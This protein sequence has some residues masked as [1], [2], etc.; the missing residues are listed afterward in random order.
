MVQGDAFD[1]L[2]L[3]DELKTAVNQDLDRI[4]PGHDYDIYK[5]YPSWTVDKNPVAEVHLANG[6]LP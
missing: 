6:S 4:L 2:L 3:Y 5:K 1:L